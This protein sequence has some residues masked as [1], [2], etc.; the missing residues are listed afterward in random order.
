MRRVLISVLLLG[1]VAGGALADGPETGVVSG[2]VTDSSGAALPGVGVTITGDRGEKFTQTGDDGSYRFALLVPGNYVVKAALEGMGEAEQPVGVT[3][4]QR[5][6]INLELRLATAE[7]IT[8]TSEAPLVDKFNVGVGQTMQSQVGVEVTGENRTFYGVINFM[9]GVTNEDENADLSSTRPNIN[10]ATWADSTVYIDGVDTT[11]S[12]YG[13]TRV[14]LPSTATTEVSLES[15]GLSADYGRTVGSATNVIVKSG[16]NNFHGEGIYNRTEEDWN[17]EYEDH[18]EMEQRESNPRDRD[19][20]RRTEEEKGQHDAQY[21]TSLGGPIARDKAWFFISVNEQNTN[22]TGKT[23]NGDFVDE[24]GKV[25]SRIAKFNLQP[26][27]KHSLALSYIDTPVLRNFVLEPVFDRYGVTPHDISGEL[28]TVSYNVSVS[29]S[30]FLEAKLA[31]QT[32][33]ENKLLAFGEFDINE[34]IATKQNDPL[35]RFPANPAA[36]QDWPGNNYGTYIDDDGWHNG[37]LLDNG[38]GTNE[39]PRTQANLAFTQFAGDHHELKYGLDAQEVEWESDVRRPNLYSGQGNNLFSATST[40]GYFNPLQPA[41]NQATASCNFLVGGASCVLQD[42]NHPSLLAD[43]GSSDT[44]SSNVALYVRDRFQVGD[45]WTFNVGVRGENQSHENDI[46]REVMDSTDISPRASMSYDIKGDGR[47]LITA[48][49]GRSFH[50]LPQEAVHEYMLDQFNGYNGYERRL[51][52]SPTNSFLGNAGFLGNTCRNTGVGYTSTLGFVLPGVHWDLVDAGVFDS[53]IE[54]YHKDE[55]ILGYEWQFSRNWAI[56]AKAIW[57]EVDNLIGST[58]Q[59]TEVDGRATFFIL[60]ANHSDYPSILRA[61]RDA[62]TIPA[63]IARMPSDANLTAYEEP[64]RDYQALQLQINR[65]FSDNWALYSNVTFSEAGGSS[66]GTVFNNTNDSYGQDLGAVLLPTHI[67]ACQV[68]QA[69]R[70]DP[71]D[72]AAAWTQFLGQPLSTIFRDGKANFDR[73]IIAKTSGWKVFPI[74]AKQS[75]TLGGHATWQS[76]ANWDRTETVTPTNPTGEPIGLGVGVPLEPE[77]SAHISS[78]WWLNVSGA[79]S[80]PVHKK[81]SG[82]VRLEVQNLTDNQEQL[83]ATG[84]GEARTLR[85]GWQRPQRFRAL[86]GIRF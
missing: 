44:K 73:P 67:T 79:Y 50:Q 9:P 53:D 2:K 27:A 16:T 74:T 14:F 30:F 12:R 15:G 35:G 49:A 23:I 22:H 19:F 45:H 82:E 5:S 11:F 75:F 80:F 64:Y 33:N 43:F 10:G 6:D 62:A 72:C 78:H 42:Y 63:V 34:A 7:T 68:N 58:I 54:A 56:D 29:E 38:F 84:R 71:R 69:N 3:A 55:A 26:S 46:G 76:G 66:H 39:Y 41:A 81:V 59:L 86:F 18:P 21:E 60:S 4:G 25:E 1:L 37:W 57:W 61:I 70:N 32:S 47:Q 52:C 77:G 51:Y 40:T 24:S 28:Y 17:A 31:D 8:V 83:S 65:R 48:S 20:F 85:R 36:N 13:G